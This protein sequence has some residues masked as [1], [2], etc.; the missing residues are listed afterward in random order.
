MVVKC[1]HAVTVG[2]VL[3]SVAVFSGCRLHRE[4]PPQPVKIIGTSYDPGGIQQAG[5]PSDSSS[6]SS[7]T[8]SGDADVPA[9]VLDPLQGRLVATQIAKQ[10]ARRELAR[11]VN[12]IEIRPGRTVGDL[13]RDDPEKRRKV[14]DLIRQAQQ[15]GL[16]KSG[17]GKCSVFLTLDLR[18]LNKILELPG[19]PIGSAPATATAAGSRQEL[20]KR[21]EKEAVENARRRALEY[22]KSLRLPGNETLGSR[23]ARD[24]KLDRAVRAKIAS[25]EPAPAAFRADGTCETAMV[26]DVAD[27]QRIIDERRRVLGLPIRLSWPKRSPL[28]RGFGSP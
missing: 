20:R 3:A 10:A 17:A 4:F 7:I 9:T 19:E 5:P 23:M 16:I 25:L 24:E 6:G 22:I 21:V 18:P 8:A 13:I 14:E 12:A 28:W 26:L 15:K 1:G 27:I 11:K 2:L